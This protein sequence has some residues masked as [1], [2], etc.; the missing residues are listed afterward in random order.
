[1]P[2]KNGWSLPQIWGS[3]THDLRVRRE[4]PGK[5]QKVQ[6][7]RNAQEVFAEAA[8]PKEHQD[9]PDLGG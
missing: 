7:Q 4:T 9:P 2:L 6:S 3:W 1:M 5:P 8:A